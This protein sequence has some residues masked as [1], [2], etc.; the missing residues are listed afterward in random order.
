MIALI[1]G[2]KPHPTADGLNPIIGIDP[3]SSLPAAGRVLNQY[4]A[5][6]AELARQWPG[7]C[8]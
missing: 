6:K 8:Q 4:P 2:L 7:L 5:E 1:K 3:R